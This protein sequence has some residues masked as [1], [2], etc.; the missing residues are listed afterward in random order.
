MNLLLLTC[1][2]LLA[3]PSLELEEVVIYGKR[4][5]SLEI[6]KKDL[7]PDSIDTFP[8]FKRYKISLNRPKYKETHPYRSSL[9][10]TSLSIGGSGTFSLF[11]GKDNFYTKVL[12]F[13]E[14]NRPDHELVFSGAGSYKDFLFKGGFNYFNYDDRIYTRA[15][16]NLGYTKSPYFASSFKTIIGE[17]DEEMEK[18]FIFKSTL[19][20]P[21]KPTTSITSL[22]F[23][24]DEKFL[25]SIK[26]VLKFNLRRF[27]VEPGVKLYSE[28]PY[29]APYLGINFYPFSLEYTRKIS[30]RT[31]DEN[32]GENPYLIGN[33]PEIWD[34]GNC[35]TGSV[36]FKK[37]EL[38]GGWT[39]KYP[40]FNRGEVDTISLSWVALCYKISYFG[41]M[42]KYNFS[43]PFYI[44]KSEISVNFGYKRFFT[45]F[46]MTNIEKYDILSASVKYEFLSSV[47]VFIKGNN[48]LYEEK[49]KVKIF[50]V[51]PERE[52]KI[53]IGVGIKI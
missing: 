36:N 15:I 6:I 52:R 29:F 8:E 33:K 16:F 32:L 3:Q 39:E 45:S 12:Y 53:Y 21:F 19:L 48:L 46:G 26:E 28:S 18:A 30:L 22:E 44:P 5:V 23:T 7:I 40:S 37:G 24:Q 51:Y 50:S 49:G 10:N 14:V 43:K 4:A 1:H 25:G 20:I 35:F 9:F 47:S 17:F 27:S 13:N 38:K 41:F 2:L 42:T 11:Y 31:R 34:Y